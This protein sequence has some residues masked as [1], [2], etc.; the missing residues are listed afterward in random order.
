ML[1]SV[2]FTISQ[3]KILQKLL[4]EIHMLALAHTQRLINILFRIINTHLTATV[5]TTCI[6]KRNNKSKTT[7]EHCSASALF[8][9]DLQCISPQCSFFSVRIGCYIALSVKSSSL[10]LL[11]HVSFVWDLHFLL[12][13]II[14]FTLWI[15]Y[16]FCIQLY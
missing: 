1:R 13:V 2:R 5:L 15:S 11:K 3:R 7:K 9:I 14:A 6:I 10:Y 16:S 8:S 4:R 12:M